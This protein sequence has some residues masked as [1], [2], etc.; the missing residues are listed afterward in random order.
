ML[1]DNSGL[2]NF[3]ST[4]TIVKVGS[5]E[6][7]SI[8]KGKIVLSF[9]KF[10]ACNTYCTGKPPRLPPEEIVCCCMTNVFAS[11][12]LLV[13]RVNAFAISVWLRL[14]SCGSEMRILT[15]PVLAAPEPV[16]PGDV[17]VNPIFFSGTE[18]FNN[19][20]NF[21]IK[22]SV[23]SNEAP[24]GAVICICNALR[25]SSGANSEGIIFTNNQIMPTHKTTIGHAIH[26]LFKKRLSE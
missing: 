14:R 6:A 16:K 7:R 17:T 25:S 15:N 23:Y 19:C 5:C 9:S 22:K 26:F 21:N 3:K 12:I 11:G 1:T 8:N 18:S 13:I 2:L 20:V 24:S 4:S 10:G